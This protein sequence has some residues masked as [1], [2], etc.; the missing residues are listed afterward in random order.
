MAVM[1]SSGWVYKIARIPNASAPAMF[2]G[3]SSMSC[4]D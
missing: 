2:S 1:V 3:R 4:L